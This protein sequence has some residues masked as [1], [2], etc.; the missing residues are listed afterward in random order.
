MTKYL[1]GT[2]QLQHTI[3]HNPFNTSGRRVFVI[4]PFDRCGLARF[5]YSN[6]HRF[7]FVQHSYFPQREVPLWRAGSIWKNLYQTVKSIC[8][9]QQGME[10]RAFTFYF[11]SELPGVFTRELHLHV[12]YVKKKKI[13]KTNANIQTNTSYS[14]KLKPISHHL[15]FI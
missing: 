7:P 10:R 1:L 9:T 8:Q 2:R 12:T 4:I 6:P 15:T 3:S 11:L 13:Q 5:N 14:L